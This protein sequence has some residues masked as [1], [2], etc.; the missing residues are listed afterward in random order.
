MISGTRLVLVVCCTAVGLSQ[1]A[2]QPY[3]S[4]PIRLLVGFGPGGGTDV[5]ARIIAPKLS[6]AMGQS[7]VV[8]NRGGVGGNLASDI[9]V[10]SNPDGHTV[11]MAINTQLT[12]NPSLYK[13]TFNVERDLKPITMIALSDQMLMVHSGVPAKSVKELVALAKQKPGGLNYSSSGAGTVDH[14]GAEL[15]S[16][17]AG[18]SMV[19]VAYK[20]GGQ[21]IASLVAG[22]TQVRVGSVTSALQLVTSGRVRALAI[23]SSKRSKLLPD[24]PTISEAGY[25]E[26]EVDVW[27]A[28]MVRDGTP[29]SIIDRIRRDTVETLQ[30]A[31][32]QASMER[33][34]VNALSSTP[35][36]VTARIRKEGAVWAGVIKD[37]GIRAE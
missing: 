20:G 1:A 17:R 3:P 30:L 4:S 8:D 32:V 35:A 10:R 37:A 36:E 7:W 2:D 9:A 22:E 29:T 19:H 14:L 21:A 25:P 15:L 34:G 18:I 23:A 33:V 26:V 24:L 31:D 27:Y 11:L 5:V 28:F 13:L 6:D 16:R 12:A